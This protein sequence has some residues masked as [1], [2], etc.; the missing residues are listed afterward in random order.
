MDSTL[1]EVAKFDDAM[2]TSSGLTITIRFTYED[3]PRLT[4]TSMLIWTVQ[5]AD[6]RLSLFVP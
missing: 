5:S 4:I 1:R 2:G 3:L 6:F